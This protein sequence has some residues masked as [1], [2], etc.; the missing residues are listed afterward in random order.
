VTK[1]ALNNPVYAGDV[2]FYQI[3]VYN[4]GPSD[5]QAVTITDTLPLS[6][7]Y[8]GGDASCSRG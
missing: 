8:V 5:A 4:D 2:I 3:V 7:T 1:T 6:T